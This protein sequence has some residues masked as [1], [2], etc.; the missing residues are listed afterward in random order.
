MIQSSRKESNINGGGEVNSPKDMATSGMPGCLAGA[1]TMT[2]TERGGGVFFLEEKNN[3]RVVRPPRQHWF[4][5]PGEGKQRRLLDTI[6][7]EN[8]P[9]CS[10]T[11]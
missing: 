4:D 8:R 5:G 6:K 10:W 11:K 9:S 3:H 2:A 1:E 7:A